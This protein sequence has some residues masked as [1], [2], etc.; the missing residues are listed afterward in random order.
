VL[1]LVLAISAPPCN[2]VTGTCRYDPRTE[3]PNPYFIEQPPEPVVVQYIAAQAQQ[4]GTFPPGATSSVVAITPTL[5][6]ANGFYTD[7]HVV[8]D[9]LV[10]IGYA[11]GGVRSE[12]F[13]LMEKGSSSGIW[14]GESVFHTRFGPITQCDQSWARIWHCR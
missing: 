12:V 7:W 5:V 4:N 6:T 1:V 9:I 11:D 3:R 8:A 2:L 13:E 14:L 10:D